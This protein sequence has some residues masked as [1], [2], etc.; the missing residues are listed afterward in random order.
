M[1]SL[2]DQQFQEQIFQLLSPVLEPY[3]FA[4]GGSGA[5][6]EW[7][8]IDRLTEDLDFSTS[9]AHEHDVPKAA[10][11]AV[12]YLRSNG[13]TV[14]SDPMFA[15]AAGM[16]R[17]RVEKGGLSSEI[18]MISD[19]RADNPVHNVHGWILSLPDAVANKVTALA[20]RGEARDYLDALTIHRSRLFTQ[21][22]LES[23]VAERF[24]DFSWPRFRTALKFMD[25]MSDEQFLIYVSP[26]VLSLDRQEAV[27]WVADLTERYGDHDYRLVDT[28]DIEPADPDW[29]AKQVAKEAQADQ[30]KTQN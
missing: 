8:L 19:Y 27:K 30:G 3:G 7:G 11:K 13:Y 16:R 17:L 29:A 25:Q 15:Q 23:I 4:L 22:Q 9:I 28:D 18:D 24:A 6:R 12:D 2:A 26:D 10:R 5:I 14:V 20:D 21:D 1:V